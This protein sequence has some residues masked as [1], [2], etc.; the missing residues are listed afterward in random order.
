M[1]TRFARV[2]IAQ[3]QFHDDLCEEIPARKVVKL[4]QRE[5]AMVFAPVKG[6]G[7][8]RLSDSAIVGT[9][10]GTMRHIHRT[11]RRVLDEQAMQG[12]DDAAGDHGVALRG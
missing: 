11:A 4:L 3:Q 10:Q 2:V 12:G 9:S 6:V 8:K 7:L 1:S 5:H